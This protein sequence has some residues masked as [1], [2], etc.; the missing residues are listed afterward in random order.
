MADSQRFL[1]TSVVKGDRSPWE[2]CRKGEVHVYKRPSRQRRVFRKP[3]LE[4]NSWV[5]DGSNCSIA[6]HLLCARQGVEQFTCS[7]WL[8]PH[9]SPGSQEV[10]TVSI[11]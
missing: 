7:T 3:G 5:N 10:F 11:L 8:N 6:E 9:L 2:V 4:V 1:D